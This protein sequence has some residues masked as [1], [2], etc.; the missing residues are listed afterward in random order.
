MRESVLVRRTPTGWLPSKLG[1]MFNVTGGEL[2]MIL[3]VALIVLGPERLPSAAR[4]LGKTMGQLRDLS[5]GFKRE[6]AQALDDPGEPIVKPARPQL[7]A[8]DGGGQSAS[9]PADVP[10]V[11]PQPL[12]ANEAEAFATAEIVSD[13][14]TE[15]S[16]AAGTDAT[17]SAPAFE[18]TGPVEHAGPVGGAGPV[19]PPDAATAGGSA[20]S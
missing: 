12:S 9:A 1:A 20:G 15:R 2:F 19:E 7:T 10:P 8:L 5:E 4:R 17:E 14:T 11:L 6:M 3:L 13:G 18:R 16:S